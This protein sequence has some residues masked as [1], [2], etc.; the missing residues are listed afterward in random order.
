LRATAVADAARDL[1]LPLREIDTVRDDSVI[2]SIVA[3]EPDVLVVVAY[4]EIV[5]P[6][7]LSAPSVAPVNVHFSL[8]PRHR[9]ADPVRAAILAGDDRTG[10]TTMWM[11]EGLDTGDLL[12]QAT[13][14]IGP[15]EDAGALGDR[16]AE[17]GGELL[18]RTLDGL[19]RGELR[20][21]AQD[22][23]AATYA[24]KIGIKSR[25]IPWTEPADAIARRV[26]ALAPEPSATTRFRD[27]GLKVHR[28]LAAPGDGQ[29][30][31]IA[32]VD[33]EGL[34]VGTGDGLLRLLEVGPE[35]RRRM[36]AAEFVRGARAQP[37]ERM[38]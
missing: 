11:D 37:G 35:G 28:A 14:A 26:R 3:A 10:V 20:R 24:P 2:R 21:T 13:A 6:D 38:G 27:K 12:L 23:A 22:E 30:G 32:A 7:V 1:E 34:D 17:L 8:L 15:E 31:A 5:P 25:T 36:S 33:P 9:G 18:V 29:P 19:A 4:G 16:L